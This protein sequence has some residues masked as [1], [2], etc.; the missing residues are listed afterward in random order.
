MEARPEG[1]SDEERPFTNISDIF[2][3]KH[4]TVE[5]NAVFP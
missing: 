4:I 1:S 2:E 5:T 3:K